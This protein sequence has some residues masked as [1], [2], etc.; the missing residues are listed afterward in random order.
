M[1]ETRLPTNINDADLDPGMKV[2]PV[3]KDEITGSTPILI[4]PELWHLTQRTSSSLSALKSKRGMDLVEA[5]KLCRETTRRLK[6][7]YFNKCD[8]GTPGQLFLKHSI[9]LVLAKHEL[10]LSYRIVY[11]GGSSEDPPAKTHVEW[12]VDSAS[13]I[14]NQCVELLTEPSFHQWPCQLRGSVPWHALSIVL[15]HLF[16]QLREPTLDHAWAAVENHL[17]RVP[18]EAKDDPLWK[19]VSKLLHQARKLRAEQG[20]QAA[21]PELAARLPE[22]VPHLGSIEGLA[23]ISPWSV[24]AG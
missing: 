24:A 3:A 17:A 16:S 20:T 7:D 9:R 15:T 11:S 8:S 19:P 4:R 2:S 1:F 23:E 22:T 13:S 10:T 14:L 21:R 6:L 18:R 5:L 12:L